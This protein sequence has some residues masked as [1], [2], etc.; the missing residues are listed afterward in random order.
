MAETEGHARLLQHLV[1][2]VMHNHG[3]NPGLCVLIDGRGA[4]RED[5]PRPI[6][7]FVPDLFA[8]T[9]P[10]SFT[11]IGEAKWYEDL[12]RPHTKA[13]LEAFLRYLKDVPSP[14]LII[15]A[16]SDLVG[17]AAAVAANARRRSMALAV[18][19]RVLTFDGQIQIP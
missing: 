5:K 6:G 3:A 8:V 10:Q 18:P 9:V 19:I 16:P 17:Y 11:I 7:G 4:A 12:L 2:W 13:Q 15:A 14:E 1:D